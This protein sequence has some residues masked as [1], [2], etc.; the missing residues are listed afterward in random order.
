MPR[1][2]E[3]LVAAALAAV[4]VRAETRGAESVESVVTAPSDDLSTPSTLHTPRVSAAKHR[5][6]ARLVPCY[7]CGRLPVGNFDDGSPRY[8]HCHDRATGLYWI[9]PQGVRFPVRV[10]PACVHEHPVGTTCLQCPVCRQTRPELAN[11][12]DV[13]LEP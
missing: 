8:D 7:T 12:D 13:E 6:G 10:C 3:S 9:N 1:D 2:V 11:D 4:V 5:P